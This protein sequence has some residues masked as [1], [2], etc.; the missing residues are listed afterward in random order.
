[1]KLKINSD[2]FPETVFERKVAPDGTTTFEP[3]KGVE[4]GTFIANIY[5]DQGVPY[6]RVMEGET[7]TD[8]ADFSDFGVEFHGV[9]NILV[10]NLVLEPNS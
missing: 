9:D 2:S 7:H 6:K 1:M 8:I 4:N 3:K 5:N 10:D